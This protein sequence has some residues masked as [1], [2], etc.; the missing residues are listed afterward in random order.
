MA[1]PVTRADRIDS[2]DVLR[3][4]AVLGILVMN[5]QSFS[6]HDAA[7]LNPHLFEM[8]RVD[9]L[10]WYAGHLLADQKFMTIFSLL[11]GAGIVL[12]TG[13]REDAG[14]EPVALHYRRMAYLI[15]FGLLHA[16]L[17]WGGDILYL[18]GVCGL[19]VYLLRRK[20]PRLLIPLGIGII[21]VASAASFV[22]GWS[23]QH[24]PAEQVEELRLNAW[25]PSPA[26]LEEEVAAMTGSYLGQVVHRAPNVLMFQT[27][28]SAVWGI[29][30]A[31][32]LMVVGMGLFKLGVLSARRSRR[33]YATMIAVGLLV[34]LPI[35]MVGVRVNDAHQWSM[36]YTFFYGSQFNYWGS[37][38]MSSAW[39]GTMMLL[40]RSNRFAALK[41]RL[42]AV[43]RMAFSNYI[44]HSIVCTFIFY[45][46]GLGEFTEVDRAGQL[47]IVAGVWTLQLLLS[48]VWLRRFRF[49]PLEWL[50]RSL[51]YRNRQPFRAASP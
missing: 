43:G 40:C 9:H 21:G 2:L 7:Y 50:W 12:F 27:F 15:L 49:G 22:F 3:G 1:G 8:G 19:W 24:W 28:I 36:D 48:P 23:M 45:G 38:F 47:L 51:S 10:I 6:S 11:F 17:V 32:G 14:E 41:N 37:L 5:I 26:M 13:R 46:W 34:G 18:Y 39:I 30:R 20:S 44:G 16:Y 33:F 25:R 4:F 29:W 35:T 31:G 42:A